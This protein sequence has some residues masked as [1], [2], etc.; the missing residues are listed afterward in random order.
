MK[1]YGVL[2]YES[3]N[4][5]EY[6]KLKW[7]NAIVNLNYDGENELKVSY[8]DKDNLFLDSFNLEVKNKGSYLAVE[9]KMILIPIPFLFFLFKEW[10]VFIYIIENDRILINFGEIIFVLIFVVGSNNNAKKF[11]FELNE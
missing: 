8:I 5:S 3:N 9:R 4:L 10:K 6:N 7:T 2:L 1:D 11:E